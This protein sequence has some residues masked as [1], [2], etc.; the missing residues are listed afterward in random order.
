MKTSKRK[1]TVVGELLERLRRYLAFLLIG[2]SDESRAGSG[3]S[4][5]R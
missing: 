1:E 4:Q 2:P 3:A 5:W